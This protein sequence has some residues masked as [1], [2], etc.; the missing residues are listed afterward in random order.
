MTD[1]DWPQGANVYYVEEGTPATRVSLGPPVFTREEADNRARE[2]G[3][4]MFKL[5]EWRVTLQPVDE[6]VSGR[7]V[8]IGPERLRTAAVNA[9]ANLEEFERQ[10][11]VAAWEPSFAPMADGTERMPVAGLTDYRNYYEVIPI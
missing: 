7:Q 2:H 6:P 4:A 11:C 8:L 9:G 10:L 3:Q 5:E 1:Q